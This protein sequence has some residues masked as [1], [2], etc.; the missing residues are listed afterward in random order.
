MAM[1]LIGID[2]TDNATSRGTGY[3]ARTL[4]A[5][6]ARRGARDR[7]VT[8]HQLLVDPRI[9][10]TSHNSAAC[11]AVETDDGAG[12]LGF[13]H[14]YVAARAAEGSDPA[15]CIARADDVRPEIIEFGRRAVSHI[16]EMAEALRLGGS[17]GFQLRELGG[18]GLGVIGAL[19]AVGLRASGNNGRF[20]DMPGLRELPDRVGSADLVRLGIR[21][22]HQ[23]ERAPGPA[24]AHETLGWVRP[25][26]IGGGPVLPVQWSEEQNAWIPVDR[27]QGHSRR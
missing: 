9:P 19:A 22:L 4:L 18:S 6:C 21:L 25:R 23:G 26:L 2:D 24:D 16:V 20:I 13:A 5:E 12:S 14:D 15:V 1:I 10:Y 7:G 11:L 27:R 17:D 8:R 3:L